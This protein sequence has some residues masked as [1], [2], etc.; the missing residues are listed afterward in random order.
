MPPKKKS[1]TSTDSG[2]FSLNRDSLSHLH[3]DSD[4]EEIEEK[5]YIKR[6]TKAKVP[7][8]LKGLEC[9]ICFKTE[10]KTYS[11]LLNHSKVHYDNIPYDLNFLSRIILRII[12]RIW[13][14]TI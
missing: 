6:L 12:L 13:N 8:L 2:N 4:D 3:T 10:Y 9:S 5:K 7:D 1:R 14:H 11:A